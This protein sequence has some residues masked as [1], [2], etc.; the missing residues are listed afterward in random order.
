MDLTTVFDFSGKTGVSGLFDIDCSAGSFD[1]SGKIEV[2]NTSSGFN[3]VLNEKSY[4][5][6]CTVEKKHGIYV[7]RDKFTNTSDSHIFLYR[8]FSRFTVL[9]NDNEVY[10]QYS[11]WNN[12]SSGSWKKLDGTIT[13]SNQGIRTT[14]GG[15]PFTT[16]WN[17][18]NERGTAFHLIPNS[19]WK[20]SVSLRPYA[21]LS[22]AAVVE[23]G[24]SDDR[25]RMEVKPHETIDMPVILFYD[26]DCR[27]D[28]GCTKLH[29]FF[30][31]EY[32]K[33]KLPVIFNT[34][35]VA[36]DDFNYDLI[37]SQA[38][39]ASELGAEY[40]VIDAGWFGE[41]EPWSSA[42]GDYR[43]KEKG[44]FFGRLKEL[45]EYI[46]S[47]GMKFGLWIEAERALAN[48]PAVRNHPEY[49]IKEAHNYFLDYANPDAN[50]YMTEVV[51]SL[52][53]KYG[54]EFIKFDFNAD[55]LYDN[56]NSS[57]YRY[58]T[59]HREFIN[60][61]RKRYP[62]MYIQNCASGGTRMDLGQSTYFD[63]VWFSD[64]QN[65]FDDIKIIRN[66]L[67]RLPPS[68]IE[69][70]AVL[71]SVD[72]FSTVYSSGKRTDRLLTVKGATWQDAE[73]VRIDYV[74]SFLSGGPIGLSCD[75]DSLLPY[76]KE[77][78]KEYI[79]EYKRMRGFYENCV[80]LPL[81]RSDSFTI[82]QYTDDEEKTVILQLFEEKS[83]QKELIVYPK[84][85]KN[86]QYILDNE[87]FTSQQ[88]TENGIRMTFNESV[89]SCTVILK[90]AY[91]EAIRERIA[92]YIP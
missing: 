60:K 76:I 9:N 86:R 15:T 4:Q 69:R 83:F 58:H 73:T 34:W 70:W 21:L 71:K 23:I 5:A 45:A 12:E 82:L 25:L 74:K 89:R 48:V 80:C 85:K 87:I 38:R 47:L 14:S 92:K 49:F 7:R 28:M 30:N 20:V 78:L 53:E 40:F 57:F 66:T 88:L 75:L 81:V 65:L 33:R 18:N 46:R 84:L 91:S 50:E 31:H 24:I 41:I 17:C 2:K 56:Q 44:A 52:V 90:D 77:Q 42:I 35:F 10:T 68:V 36:F 64:N 51:C 72:G 54:I 61:L 16:L 79:E 26:F 22:N 63:G 11:C 39:S 55:C 32:P 67:L 1:G 29:Y 3:A 8:Y 59:G 62:D 13:V 43:E 19:A 6:T 27:T 37:A